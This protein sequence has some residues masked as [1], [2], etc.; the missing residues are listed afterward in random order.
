VLA[1]A[2]RSPDF[3]TSG[4]ELM[5]GYT[6]QFGLKLDG[7]IAIDPV[8][9]QQLMTQI[10]S[11]STPGYGEIN[12]GNFAQKLL[13]DSYAQYPNPV[14]RHQYNNMLMTTLLRQVLHGGHMIGK[15]KALRDAARGGHLQILMNDPTVQTQVVKA[16]LLRTL[17]PAGQ[18]DVLGVYTTN[19][20]AS[21]VDYW[22][23]RRVDQRVTVNADGSVNVVRTMTLTNAAPAYSWTGT[24]PGGGYFTRISKPKVSMYVPGNARVGQVTVDGAAVIPS[25]LTERGLGVVYLPAVTVARGDTL[26]VVL[27]YTLPK[28][29]VGSAGY[30]LAVAAQPTLL[31]VPLTITVSG[32]GACT[33][34]GAGW[35]SAG[36]AARYSAR[37]TSVF[38]GSVVCR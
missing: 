18:G 6:A 34:T 20:N 4:E 35:S 36:K 32:P 7:V 31:P 23:R 9:M 8:A 29:T 25:L 3:R 16:D 10:P 2:D 28:G 21:K 14:E 27:R 12:A 13:V 15:G 38:R 22:Q 24:D 5:R 30:Q 17:P 26:K 11:F 1:A 33:A 37:D 19:S